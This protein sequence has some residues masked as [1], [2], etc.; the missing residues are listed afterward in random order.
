[1]FNRSYYS[2]LT[3]GDGKGPFSKW[4]QVQCVCDDKTLNIMEHNILC[5]K[6]YYY[7]RHRLI[8]VSQTQSFCFF[9]SYLLILHINSIQGDSC[10]TDNTEGDDFIELCDQRSSCKYVSDFGWLWSYGHLKL[11]T[12]GKDSWYKL[13]KI[14]NNYIP[15][16]CEV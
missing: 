3:W 2:L 11:Q 16:K 1:M 4:F 15:H 8:W 6:H 5:Y 9:H 12:D 13:N 7:F 14:I 10:L